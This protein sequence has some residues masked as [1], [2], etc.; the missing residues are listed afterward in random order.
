MT[1]KTLVVFLFSQLGLVSYGNA[2]NPTDWPVHALDRPQPRVVDP[3][4]PGTM[5]PAPSDAIVLFD[6]RDLSRWRSRGQI[7][8]WKVVDGYFEVV[9]GTGSLVSADAFGDVHL[10]VEWAAPAVVKGAGQDPGNSGVYLMDLYEVQVLDSF[11]NTT[12]PDGQAAAIYG[13]FPPLVNVS[14]AP[15]Q[16]QSFDIFFRAPRF[17]DA[18]TL[19]QPARMTALHNNIVVHNNVEL[20]GPTAHRA[21]P[22]YRAHAARLPIS[23]QDHGQPVRYRNIWIRPLEP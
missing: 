4:P 14:R 19:L 21:R 8:Q 15:G 16:W 13:Q 6:G 10:H 20:T 23:L 11:G 17:D 18:G 7:A 22:P 3:G 12:Y 9:P 5:A 2:Q 1:K